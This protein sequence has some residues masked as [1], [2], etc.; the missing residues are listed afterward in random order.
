MGR[1]L[2]GSSNHRIRGTAIQI[3]AVGWATRAFA[4]FTRFDNVIST[5]RSAIIIVKVITAGSTAPIAVNALINIRV[6]TGDVTRSGR[7]GKHIGGAGIIVRTIGGAIA[8]ANFT[9]FDKAITTTSQ[10]I[11]VIK[12]VAPCGAAA[13]TR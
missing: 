2:A 4:I 7:T 13:I 8:I 5:D 11:G 12:T 6:S 9:A 1:A 3:K 10:T